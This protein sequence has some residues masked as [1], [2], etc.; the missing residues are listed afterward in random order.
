MKIDEETVISILK[1]IKLFAFDM[2]GVLRIGNHPIDGSDKIFK[3]IE[4]LNKKSIII[5]NE[6]R[7]TPDTIK[8]DLQEMG[9]DIGNT[10]VL[11][12]GI[13]I[14][15]YFKKKAE[16]LPD[17]NISLGIVGENGLYDTINPLTSIS[18][19][20]ICETPPKYKTN[21][22]LIIG[23]LNKIKISNLEK[24][25]KWV[26]TDTKILLTCEDFADPSSKGDFT[27]GMP[28]HILHMTNYNIKSNYYSL[29][30][31]NPKVAHLIINTY[32][33]IKPHEILFVGDTISTDI[34]LAEEN[35]FK[36]LLVL[37]G[38]TKKEGIKSHVIQPDIV[39]ESVK[40]LNN[41]LKKMIN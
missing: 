8:E 30:K 28:R 14:Y 10:T 34:R 5:T 35:G 1:D 25:L 39:L 11:T 40:E 9:V 20:E 26:K 17:Q 22:Y 31:P 19:I 36:S 27:I 33:N 16:S 12:A 6:C 38:N 15:T 21:L 3:N 23:S 29:G 32:P 37:S 13:S 2:D 7:Y 18:N 41:F 4:N 24:V